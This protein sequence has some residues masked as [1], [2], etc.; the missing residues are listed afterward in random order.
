MKTVY[1]VRHGQTIL[2]HFRRM[3]GWIDSPLT[4]T[5]E[6][7]AT[8]T[9]KMLNQVHFDVAIS[10]DLGRAIVTRDLILAENKVTDIAPMINKNF[11][12]VYFGSFEGVDSVVTWNQ[13]GGPQGSF[14]QDFLIKKYGLLAV[15]DFMHDADPFKEAETG[16]QLQN[17]IQNAFTGLQNQLKDGETALVVSHGTFIRNVAGLYSKP[18]TFIDQPENGSVAILDVTDKPI[19]VDYNQTEI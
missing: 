18:G 15:R 13:I 11:R 9:G 17:R 8:N 5:G 16:E 14:D 2:N 3:Q 1:L 7:Q 4:Q 10:S 12:E 6:Q 19:L